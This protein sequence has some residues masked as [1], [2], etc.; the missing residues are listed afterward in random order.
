MGRHWREEGRVEGRVEGREEGRESFRV[1]E[2]RGS[3]W[4][5]S[6]RTDGQTDRQTNR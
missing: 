2:G 5:D 4:P 1:T 3:D 6:D